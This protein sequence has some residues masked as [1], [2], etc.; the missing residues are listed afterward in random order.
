MS[1]SYSEPSRQ[2]IAASLCS[3]AHLHALAPR[4]RAL[5]PLQSS[6]RCE[7]E[8]DVRQLSR[9]VSELE[10]DHKALPI[11]MK[12]YVK[13]GGQFLAFSVDPAFQ[14]AMDGLVVV[15]LDRTSSRLLSLHMG[16][17][18]YQRFRSHGTPAPQPSVVY[19]QP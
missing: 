15:D 17:E 1:A 3:G 11:L 14:A 9:R 19:S 13:L 4:V 8:A 16:P 12:E 18:N 5:H 6:A 10:S 2:L 7:T